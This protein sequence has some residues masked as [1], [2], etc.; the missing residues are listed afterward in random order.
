MPAGSVLP[1][2]PAGAG[3]AGPVGPTGPQGDTGPAGPTGDTGPQGDTGPVGP[4]G[5]TGATGATG[6]SGATTFANIYD[7]VIG[8][9]IDDWS[10]ITIPANTLSAD[11]QELEFQFVIAGLDPASSVPVDFAGATIGTIV[12]TPGGTVISGTVR[13]CRQSNVLAACSIATSHGYSNQADTGAIDL[14][15]TAYDIDVTS[16]SGTIKKLRIDWKA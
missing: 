15:T 2:S 7:N 11:G 12:D 1:P 5:D 14:T 4:T 8:L 16:T 6:T 10:N 9:N 13:I 3:P